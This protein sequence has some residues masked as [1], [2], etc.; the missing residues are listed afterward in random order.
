MVLSF[1]VTFFCPT[2]QDV[3]FLYIYY[4]H[5]ASNF[6]S[7]YEGNLMDFYFF[8]NS[9]IPKSSE[10]FTIINALDIQQNQSGEKSR[11]YL[12]KPDS[13]YCKTY[14]ILFY[15]RLQKYSI[16]KFKLHRYY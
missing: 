3:N 16:I 12:F 5:H 6:S 1:C 8:H 10:V 7:K 13:S 9:M 11:R 4:L 2:L 15:R 14:N